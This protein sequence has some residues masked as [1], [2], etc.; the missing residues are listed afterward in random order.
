[1]LAGAVSPTG[2]RNEY[3]TAERVLHSCMTSEE[4]L[5]FY[6]YMD[7]LREA[8]QESVYAAVEGVATRRGLMYAA[9]KH[10]SGSS[11]EPL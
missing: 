6:S 3:D 8:T 5:S 2:T 11:S 7:A 4:G 1:M 10:T 9:P